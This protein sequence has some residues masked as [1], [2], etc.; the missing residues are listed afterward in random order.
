MK[1][2]AIFSSIAT[3]S[4]LLGITSGGTIAKMAHEEMPSTEPTGEFQPIDQPLWVK[5]AVTIGGLGLIGLELWWFVFSQP[6]SR[7]AATQEGIQEVTI[8]VDGGYE[9]SQIVVQVG[10]PV[11]LNFDRKDPNHCLEAVQLPDFHIAQ[12]LPLNQVTAI[13]FTPDKPGRYE[14]TCGM[15]MFRGVIEAQPATT[16]QVNGVQG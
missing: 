14:F 6:K 13:E 11:R 3:V 10:H 1:Q 8:T 5:G 4:I 9:P 15:N 16:P 12:D 7:Q 2:S